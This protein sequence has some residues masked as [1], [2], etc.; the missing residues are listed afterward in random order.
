MTFRNRPLARAAALCTAAI[1]GLGAAP[2]ALAQAYPAKTLKILVGFAP[3]GAMDIVARTV[4]QKMAPSLGQAVVIENKPGAASN[5]AIRQ[6][7]ESPPDGYTVML[8]ANGLTANPLLYTQQPFDPNADVTPIS[9]VA[10]LPVVIAANPKSEVTS[11][12]KLVEISK[13]K[14]GSLNYGSPGNGSTPHLAVELFARGAGIQLSHIPY[15]GGKPA[16]ADVLG[17]QLPLVAV[18]A[19]E[20][21]PLWKDGKLKVLAALSAQRVATMPDVPTIAES[22]FPGFEANVW[23]A[24]IAPKG[25]PPAIIEKLRA[26]IHKALADP[27]VKERLANLGAEVAPSTQQELAALVRAEHERYAKLVREAGIKAN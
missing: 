18:N 27:E 3:G 5:I 19:V 13:A 8:V 20:V 1:L 14:P 17:G 6:L 25:T 2:A 24:F 4:G 23:H 22:G 26:E 21:Q 15:K 11:L 10:R 9:L 12:A 16:I 7:I